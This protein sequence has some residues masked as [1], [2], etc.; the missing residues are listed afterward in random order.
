MM[1][2]LSATNLF[3]DWL[4]AILVALCGCC[5]LAVLRAPDV[6]ETPPLEAIRRIKLAGFSILTLR[7]WYVLLQG[8][9]LVV[10]APT[11]IGLTLLFTA[12]LFKSLYRLFQTKVD[13]FISRRH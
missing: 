4:M 6:V 8:H 13:A 2:I 5:H 1:T 11:E 12:D 10:P 3:A 9:D 7:Y